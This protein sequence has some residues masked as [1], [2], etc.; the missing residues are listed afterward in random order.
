M[1]AGYRDPDL[2]N[3]QAW[4]A[5]QNTCRNVVRSVL[6]ERHALLDVGFSV[7]HSMCKQLDD[8]ARAWSINEQVVRRDWL[9]NI[10]PEGHEVIS[11]PFG[12]QIA[13]IVNPEGA[14]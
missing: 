11:T 4:A 8:V 1:A 9:Y 13:Q 6:A 14:H 2:T 12:Y 5:M 10:C 7:E 3:E